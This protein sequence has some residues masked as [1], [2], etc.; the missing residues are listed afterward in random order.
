[1]DDVRR[2]LAEVEA[3]ELDLDSFAAAHAEGGFVL[4]VR[5]DDEFR[6]GHV[7]G[8]H[9]V[10]MQEVPDRLDELPRDQRVHVICRSGSRSRQVVDYLRSQGVDA[11]NVADG[12]GGWAARGWPL[13]R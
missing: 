1:M 8:A 11:A 9:H 12:T 2:Q 10:P 7:P 3:G 13:E 6:S 4:D 5:E